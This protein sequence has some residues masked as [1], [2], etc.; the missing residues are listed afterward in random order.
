MAEQAQARRTP[1]PAPPAGARRKYTYRELVDSYRAEYPGEFDQF[2][3]S[4]LA[5]AILAENPEFRGILDESSRG[6]ESV[7]LP[8]LDEAA[9]RQRAAPKYDAK[10]LVGHPAGVPLPDPKQLRTPTYT[11]MAI[12]A[13]LVAVPSLMGG[14]I[15]AAAGGGVASV[16]GGT[17]GLVA[18][19]AA[20]EFLR[21]GYQTWSGSRNDGFSLPNIA[22]QGVINAFPFARAAAPGIRALAPELVER[23][24][25]SVARVA[26]STFEGA[27]ASGTSTAAEAVIRDRR[28]PELG[29]LAGSAAFGGAFG[30]GFGG[31]AEMLAQIRAT[32]AMPDPAVV[33]SHFAGLRDPGTRTAA[34][35]AIYDL[36]DAVGGHVPERGAAILQRL[37]QEANVLAQQDLQ[38]FAATFVQDFG[39]R[40]DTLTMDGQAGEIDQFLEG[41]KQR[42]AAQE[43]LQKAG[44]ILTQIRETSS[45]RPIDQPSAVG[46]HTPYDPGRMHGPEV[47]P[48]STR[49]EQRF[50]EAFEKSLD[51]PPLVRE[52]PPSLIPETATEARPAYSTAKNPPP[53]PEQQ[54]LGIKPPKDPLRPGPDV[55]TPPELVQ[56]GVDLLPGVQSGVVSRDEALMLHWLSR[57]LREMSYQPSSRMRGATEQEVTRDARSQEEARAMAYSPAVAGTPVIQMFDTLG[58]GM[59]R[60]QVATQIENLLEGKARRPGKAAVAAQKL[61]RAMLEAWVPAERRFDW[62]LVSSETLKATGLPL[63]VGFKTPYTPL[64]FHVADQPADLVEKFL[65]G[66]RARRAAMEEEAPGMPG[67]RPEDLA[68]DD[69]AEARQIVRSASDADLQRLYAEMTDYSARAEDLEGADDFSGGWYDVGPGLIAAELERRGLGKYTQKSLEMEGPGTP[70]RSKLIPDEP[71]EYTPTLA[72]ATDKVRRLREAGNTG[73]EYL[74]ALRT[75]ER[76]AA[77]EDATLP[78]T[79]EQPALLP[80]VRESE[81]ATPVLMRE[82]EL[83]SLTPEDARPKSRLKQPP[84][85]GDETGAV[86]RV[87]DVKMQREAAQRDV[88]ISAA[89]FDDLAQT[90]KAAGDTE[91]AGLLVGDPD[92]TVRRVILSDNRAANPAKQFEIGADVVQRAQVFAAQRGWTLLA[93]FHSQPTGSAE[94]SKL[95]LKGNVADLPMLIVGARAGSVRDV[96]I[97]QPQGKNVPWLEGNVRV[98]D[99]PVVP[100]TQVPPSVASFAIDQI[101]RFEGAPGD[102]PA[103][104]DYLRSH[105]VEFGASP[106]Y[107]RAQQFIDE[108]NPRQAWIELQAATLA[109]QKGARALAQATPTTD[110]HRAALLARVEQATA[111]GPQDPVGALFA[112]YDG[113]TTWV[114]GVGRVVV[115]PSVP[116]ALKGKGV[117]AG[118][119]GILRPGAADIPLPSESQ[120]VG[121]TIEALNKV[122]EDT[123]ASAILDDPSKSSFTLL[124]RQ[125]AEQLMLRAPSS[126][127]ATKALRTAMKRQGVSD[128]EI[129]RQIASHLTTTAT[130]SAKFLAALSVWKSRNRDAIRSIE[131]IRGASGE[132]DD[133]MIIG[134]GGRRI[135]RLGDLAPVDTFKDIVTPTRAWDR[136][137]LLNSLTRE[138]RGAFDLFE[139][140]SRAFMLSQWATAARN[141]WSV[142]ARWGVEMF[143]ELGSA[144][145]STTFG[146]P[147]RALNHLRRAGDMMR[148][149]PALRPDGWVMPWHA[150]QAQWEQIFTSTSWLAGLK[151]KER[152]AAETLLA[153]IPEEQAHFLG[154]VG[155][156]EPTPHGQSRYRILNWI[157]QPKVQNFLTMFNRAQEF[158]ARSGMYIVNLR[159]GLRAKGLDPDL[160]WQL[161]PADLAAKL[162]GDDAMRRLLHDSVAG[163]LDYTFSGET[164]RRGFG[165]DAQGRP[166]GAW[167][168][169]LIDGVQ[170]HPTIRAGY[171]WPRFNLS[172]A[173]RFIWDHSGVNAVVESLNNVLLQY[174]ASSKAGM[175]IRAGLTAGGEAA[176]Q[177]V[178]LP[179]GFGATVG[180]TISAFGGAHRGRF[181]LGRKAAQFEQEQIPEA[182]GQFRDAQAALGEQLQTVQTLSREHTVQ[183]RLVARADRRGLS[184][185]AA[186]G[187]T[188]LEELNAALEREMRRYEEAESSMKGWKAQADELWKDVEQAKAVRAPQTYAE[189]WGRAGA[190]MATMMVPALLLRAEQQD[191]GTKW[192]E[193]RYDIP[194]LGDTVID[195]R[196]LAPFTQYLF[197]ADVINDM[198]A[199]TDWA[200]VYE[201]LQA[202]VPMSEAVYGRYEGKY[203]AKSMGLQAMNAFL[204]MSQAAGT[205][206]A[207]V[208]EFTAL[209]ERGID[210]QRIGAATITAIGNLLA[211][212]TIPF[213]QF[214][215]ATDFL[216]PEESNARITST[217]QGGLAPLAQPLGNLPFIGAAVIPPTYNQLTGQ[218]LDAYMPWLRASMGVTLRQWNR[219]AGEINDT[220]TAG[221]SVYIR[222]THD[223]FLDR[224]VGFH[225]S[226]AVSQYA[227]PLIFANEYYLSLDSPATRRDYLQS[228]VF[229]ALK[230]YAIG[231]AMVDVGW[232]RMAEAREGGEQRRRRLRWERLNAL[233]GEEGIS[234]AEGAATGDAPAEEP[235][236]PEAPEM[237]VPDAPAERGPS[238]A[239]GGPQAR[240]SAPEFKEE[241]RRPA[242]DRA[243]S[244]RL[245]PAPELEA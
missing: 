198:D 201:D 241:D 169:W 196:P 148:Y 235:D 222:A 138:E 5:D 135:G 65:P 173:P 157:S 112:L 214:K 8:D 185:Q 221:A 106:W 242:F 4:D 176:G 91:V 192:Y 183:K 238:G 123:K 89:D 20:G 85:F 227:D 37:Q 141:F 217:D 25:P 27:V 15:G 149:V 88:Q 30:A 132:I 2:D 46:W 49:T 147:A 93:S 118:P 1:P 243:L 200:G 44:D 97:W 71:P 136:A 122:L 29:E 68:P 50:G 213:A 179:P 84:L 164:I 212:F 230:K 45:P 236:T 167:Y 181:Y 10:G 203:T 225:Y 170:K 234:F 86:G 58:I 191:K 95:D 189:L 190:G 137:M 240:L 177:F 126:W 226:Q 100:G 211:R 245:R 73:P 114:E 38:Q 113:R 53:L 22:A 74:E 24:A 210:P 33:E 128:Y 231:Q 199:E 41:L 220:G 55:G 14:A 3:P 80:E 18:G 61:S 171:P 47:D 92:G 139:S 34:A 119:G 35:Q 154:S 237:T 215:G 209:G 62:S 32:G 195:T 168:D 67:T 129:N 142:N 218:P 9:G 151:G 115:A 197:F 165:K 208:E 207:V 229:P 6:T 219:V 140:S 205:T 69:V 143:D 76:L 66:E 133:V 31:G 239:Q 233:A 131:G 23:V 59:T 81:R 117:T 134:A 64:G 216:S 19:G 187:R 155:F 111:A 13:G 166:K 152:L 193:L 82:E 99:A 174:G 120:V 116:P 224:L 54:E 108:G 98:A 11:D 110:A 12:E 244:P 175:A 232:K 96:K 36:A 75:E 102:A 153:G 145:A 40:A 105:S 160:L 125:I 43:I 124:N 206:L 56:R 103:I 48:G 77:A 87:K 182:M 83:F 52:G 204:S 94:P 109:T 158:T 60:G 130:Q 194:G 7:T 28:L 180:G 72:E 121:M 188:R 146:R 21:E 57:E 163:A 70:G 159:D 127:G 150:R 156:G 184:Q 16:P 178:G 101:P 161:P 90:I 202:G 42:G 172:A 104:Q 144:I 78:P 162:G 107:V 223:P 39:R 26:K 228:T 17:A 51:R 186:A 79:L 63:R